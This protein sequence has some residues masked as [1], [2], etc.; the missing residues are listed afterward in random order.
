MSPLPMVC[1]LSLHL[2]LNGLV[3]DEANAEG[4]D[5]LL[6]NWALHIGLRTSEPASLTLHEQDIPLD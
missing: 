4:T 5:A 6:A 2:E 3:Q 1:P